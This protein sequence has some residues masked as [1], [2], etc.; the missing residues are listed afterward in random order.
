MTPTLFGRWQQRLLLL[1]TVGLLLSLPLAI[2]Q[3][4]WY[5]L[6]VL[7][8]I[9]FFGCLWDLL[10]QQ[11][12]RLRWDNDW[13]YLWQLAGGISEGLFLLILLKGNLLLGIDLGKLAG[14]WLFLHYVMVSAAMFVA[15]QSLLTVF[16]PHARYR[17]RQWL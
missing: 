6:L 17:G 15:A 10:Y 8:Y 2:I 13:P 9:G 11:L 7:I 16:F 12:Q 14:G 4:S 5:Y 3:R 1:P